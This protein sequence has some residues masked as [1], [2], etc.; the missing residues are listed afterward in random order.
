MEVARLRAAIRHIGVAEEAARK[1]TWSGKD[2]VLASVE[3]LRAKA[4]EALAEAEADNASVYVSP[5][6]AFLEAICLF[7]GFRDSD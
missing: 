4:G 3:A 5:K 7:A 2:A 6:I 1:A